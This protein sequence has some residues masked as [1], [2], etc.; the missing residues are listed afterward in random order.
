MAVYTNI[1][2]T[3][4]FEDLIPRSTSTSIGTIAKG[5]KS[6]NPGAIKKIIIS[7]YDDQAAAGVSIWIEDAAFQEASH[8][9]NNK[10]YFIKDIVIP[11]AVT[12]VLDDNVSYD[13]SVYALRIST[14]NAAD[15]GDGKISIIIK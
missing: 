7:N 14:S 1:T 9:N 5:T 11:V 15:G 13:G 12:L 2:S 10:Y 4:P 8:A 3:V 6:A